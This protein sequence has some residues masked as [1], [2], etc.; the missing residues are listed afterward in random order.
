MKIYLRHIKKFGGYIFSRQ[1][2]PRR[3]YNLIRAIISWKITKSLKLNTY[4]ITLTIC[5][6]NICNLSCELCPVGLKF[7]GRK[8]GFMKFQDFKKI[9]DEVGPYIYELYLFN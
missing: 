2:T 1:N 9:I 6:G 8:K 3:T 7:K 4:P 5:P